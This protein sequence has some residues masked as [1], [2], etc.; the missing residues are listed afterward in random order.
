MTKLTA[1]AALLAGEHRYSLSRSHADMALMDPSHRV[2]N[3]IMLNPSTADHREDDPTI[4][5]CCG[6]AERAGFTKLV[7][8]NLCAYR[9]TDPKEL[10]AVWKRNPAH[11]IGPE[12]LDNIELFSRHAHLVIAA[13]GANA[14]RLYLGPGRSIDPPPVWHVDTVL[15]VLRG[16]HGEVRALR[17]NDNGSPQHPLYI[18]YDVLDSPASIAKLPYV[19]KP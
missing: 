15:D 9:T 4:R 14:A 11:A 18:P 3:F 16:L 17:L 6:F 19:V 13:W 10:I 8:T 7:V 1:K 5:K 12:N 2:V